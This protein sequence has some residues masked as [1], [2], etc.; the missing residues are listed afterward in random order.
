MQDF[1]TICKKKI[2]QTPRMA[3]LRG[4]EYW[5][6]AI[7]GNEGCFGNSSDAPMAKLDNWE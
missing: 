5:K 4:C 6:S 2:T 1:F 7:R 3:F